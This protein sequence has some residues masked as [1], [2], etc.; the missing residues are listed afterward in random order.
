MILNL[1]YKDNLKELGL[2]SLEERRKRG[3]MI[4]TWKILYHHDHILENLIQP[5]Q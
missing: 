5:Q 3:D 1:S 4:K 2:P